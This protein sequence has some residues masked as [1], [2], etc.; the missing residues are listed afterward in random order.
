VNRKIR[1]TTPRC[2]PGLRPRDRGVVHL[3]DEHDEV[4]DAGRFG[5]HGVLARL[6]AAVEARLELALARRDHLGNT[7]RLLVLKGK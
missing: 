7:R 1:S 5:Q 3:V 6:P 2:A 4:F